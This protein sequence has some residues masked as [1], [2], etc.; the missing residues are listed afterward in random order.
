M[1]AGRE[2]GRVG[3]DCTM[4]GEGEGGGSERVVTGLGRQDRIGIGLCIH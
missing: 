1:T 2:G 3:P 4:W